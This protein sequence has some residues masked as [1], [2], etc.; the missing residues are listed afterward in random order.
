MRGLEDEEEVTQKRE[1]EC[2]EELLRND[3]VL[4]WPSSLETIMDWHEVQGVRIY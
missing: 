3:S 4:T 1:A 2:D